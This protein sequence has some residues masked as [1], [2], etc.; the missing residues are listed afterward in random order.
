M[1]VELDMEFYLIVL[2]IYLHLSFLHLISL[3]SIHR[4]SRVQDGLNLRVIKE[5][6]CGT[7]KVVTVIVIQG[8]V[9]GLS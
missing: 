7:C 2:R 5:C 3:I 4:L 8:R 9:A 6:A 1:A